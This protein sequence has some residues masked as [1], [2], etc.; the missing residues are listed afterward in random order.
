MDIKTL[1][2][3]DIMPDIYNSD[4]SISAVKKHI[5]TLEKS[6]KEDPNNTDIMLLKNG[7]SEYCMLLG[8]Q[9]TTDRNKKIFDYIHKKVISNY[10]KYFIKTAAR[11]KGLLSFYNKCRI[12]LYDRVSLDTIKDIY[13][14][15]TVVDSKEGDTIS[16]LEVCYSIMDKVIDYM[17]SL[18]FIPCE[19]EVPKDTTGFNI[20]NFPDIIIPDKSYMSE[21]NV[22][23][24]KDYILHPKSDTGYQSLHVIFKD[25]Y[26]KYLEYQVRTYSM[27]FH[28]EHGLASHYLFKLNQLKEKNIPELIIDRSKIKV[29]GY[30]FINDILCD[31]SGIEN[32]VSIFECSYRAN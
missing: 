5:L 30:K 25:K 32:S 18:G 24:V 19:A 10:P 23:Y 21:K 3:P 6:I 16:L 9:H 7:L 15:R 12:K 4:S 28:S 2:L 11:I 26:G 8:N 22:K 13:G 27:D 17:I 29:P 31:D 14:C 20:C 1:I